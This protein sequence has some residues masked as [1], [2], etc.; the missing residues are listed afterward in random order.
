[1]VFPGSGRPQ[2][3][4]Q[5]K[6]QATPVGKAH[7]ALNYLR[8]IRCLVESFNQSK[9]VCFRARA[10]SAAI[11]DFQLFLPQRS[12]IELALPAHRESLINKL[13]IQ[14]LSI[15]G[16]TPEWGASK[17]SG[18]AHQVNNVFLHLAL[19]FT[20]QTIVTRSPEMRSCWMTHFTKTFPAFAQNIWS[21]QDGNEMQIFALEI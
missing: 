10:A 2:N 8:V 15:C 6:L 13:R 21:S 1:M 9:R 20:F 18:A 11:M 19:V 4:H 5:Q 16:V 3:T 12:N 17:R 14:T 7:Q